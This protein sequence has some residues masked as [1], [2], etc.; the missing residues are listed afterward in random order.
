MSEC[1]KVAQPADAI[2]LT[3]DGVYAAAS[4]QA[5]KLQSFVKAGSIF[6]L[7]EDLLARGVEASEGIKSINTAEFVNLCTQHNPIQSWF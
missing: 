1:I 4:V 7:A 5:E 6:A 3:E 2:I